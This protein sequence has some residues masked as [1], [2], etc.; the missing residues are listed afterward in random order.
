MK[1]VILYN[2]DEQRKET[3]KNILSDDIKIKFIEKSEINEIVCDIFDDNEKNMNHNQENEPIFDNEF[4]LIQG[5]DTDDELTDLL[6]SFKSKLVPR[7]ITSAR[8]QE[9]EKWMLK[10]LLKEIFEEDEM[11]KKNL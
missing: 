8:T 4:M 9:N 1:K 3:I 6:F 11:M 10:D 2:L 5:F 7:P